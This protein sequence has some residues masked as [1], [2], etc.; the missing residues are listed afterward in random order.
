MAVSRGQ[1]E[2]LT[3]PKPRAVRVLSVYL[4]FKLFK[5]AIQASYS[6]SYSS[7]LFKV[8]AVILYHESG[9][10]SFHMLVNVVRSGMFATY[11]FGFCPGCASC[12]VEP[13]N[14]E[15]GRITAGLFDIHMTRSCLPALA[16]VFPDAAS[17]QASFPYATVL[18]QKPRRGSPGWR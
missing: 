16:R 17:L 11:Q 3:V 13:D 1:E 6:R 18:L 2:L 7:K 12:T 14:V 10:P 4:P 5:Q 9:P 15:W 8:P